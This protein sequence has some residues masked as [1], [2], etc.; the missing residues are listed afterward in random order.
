MKREGAADC[1]ALCVFIKANIDCNV[2]GSF[3]LL[4]VIR[5]KTVYNEVK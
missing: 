2:R 1:S 3:L 5:E 4:I